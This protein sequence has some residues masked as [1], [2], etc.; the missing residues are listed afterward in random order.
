MGSPN[1]TSLITGTGG[2]MEKP[3]LE[4][5]S[6]SPRETNHPWTRPLALPRPWVTSSPELWPIVPRLNYLLNI[7]TWIPMCPKS[8]SWCS[9]G[10]APKVTPFPGSP[11]ALMSPVLL[12]TLDK[13]TWSHVSH[14]FSLTRTLNASAHLSLYLQTHPASDDFLSSQV[15]T[16]T[17][18][19]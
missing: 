13:T 18:C 8:N 10:T 17:N 7:T 6:G 9:T 12:V 1:T 4:A 15:Y 11:Y 3:L 14:P 19:F 5:S 16:S 2:T